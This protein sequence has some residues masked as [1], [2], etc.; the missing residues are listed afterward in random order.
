[1]MQRPTRLMWPISP[2]RLSRR[3]IKLT[4]R[5]TPMKPTRLTR[6]KPKL[7]PKAKLWPKTHSPSQNIPQSSRK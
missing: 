1:M 6:P 3:P 7:R 2:P 5:P 4:M